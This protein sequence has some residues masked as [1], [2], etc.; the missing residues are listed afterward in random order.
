[1]SKP[2]ADS[3]LLSHLKRLA[4][5]DISKDDEMPMT[6][7]EALAKTMWEMA[8]GYEIELDDGNTRRYGPD[9]VMAKEVFDRIEGRVPTTDARDQ[10]QKASVSDR[11]GDE[12]RKR[13]NA[14]AEN[15]DNSS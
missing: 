1:M 12:S 10:K 14:L 3:P 13:L 8:L 11:V 5:E 6:R 15:T 2:K 4:K 9:K 7:A